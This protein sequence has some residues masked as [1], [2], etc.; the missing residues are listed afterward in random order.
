VNLKYISWGVLVAAFTLVAILIGLIPIYAAISETKNDLN[1]C[2]KQLSEANT[3]LDGW[4]MPS[5]FRVGVCNGEQTLCICGNP[6][7][8]SDNIKQVVK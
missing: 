1:A 5:P 2:T 7:K 3:A 8:F 4:C 6:E